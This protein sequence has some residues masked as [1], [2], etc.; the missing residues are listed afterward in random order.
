MTDI[1]KLEDKY[2]KT[3]NTV[4]KAEI[5]KMKFYN[6]WDINHD[7]KDR[8]D[9]NNTLRDARD[10]HFKIVDTL[11]IKREKTK[12]KTQLKLNLTTE[13]ECIDYVKNKGYLWDIPS[14]LIN[15]AVA[16][17]A[18][19]KCGSNLRYIPKNILTNH[20]CLIA[21]EDWGYIIKYVPKIFLTDQMYLAALCSLIDALSHIPIHI[22]YKVKRKLEI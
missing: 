6:S 11:A 13:Q 16:L 7:F 19:I 15:E 1:K 5:Q 2:W 18:V 8:K 4:R 17:A 20:M 9:I 22:K 12:I 21:V 10:S 3:R 14:N